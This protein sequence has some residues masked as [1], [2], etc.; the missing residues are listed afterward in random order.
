VSSQRRPSREAG[1]DCVGL[2]VAGLPLAAAAAWLTRRSSMGWRY[3]S[4]VSSAAVAGVAG[5]TTWWVRALVPTQ[6]RP[7]GV[8]PLVLGT[9]ASYLSMRIGLFTGWTKT[10]KHGVVDPLGGDVDDATTWMVAAIGPAA[11]LS[12]LAAGRRAGA[13]SS[14]AGGRT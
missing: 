5:L 13:R 1:S 11:V 9:G 14:R 3:P 10:F 4:T 12:V 2:V 6:W 8:A 7:T